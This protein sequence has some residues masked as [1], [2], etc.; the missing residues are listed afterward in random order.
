MGKVKIGEL[1][2]HPIIAGDINLKNKHEIHITQ[3]FKSLGGDSGNTKPDNPDNPS[4]NDYEIA[5]EE[6]IND[7]ATDIFNA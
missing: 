2:G 4:Y 6:D 1:R 3:L 5:T 7:I